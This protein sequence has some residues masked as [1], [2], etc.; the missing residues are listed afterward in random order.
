M[1]QFISTLA[2]PT[3]ELLASIDGTLPV[4]WTLTA[5]AYENAA[6]VA[7]GTF[8]PTAFSGTSDG[9]VVAPA[10]YGLSD[11]VVIIPKAVTILPILFIL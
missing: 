10:P 7:S 5:K 3:G 2:A 4:G 8:N 6:L 9:S 1:Q 11:V